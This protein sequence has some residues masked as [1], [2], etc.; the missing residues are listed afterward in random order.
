MES[1]A[2]LRARLMHDAIPLLF[3]QKIGM[4]SEILK[5]VFSDDYKLHSLNFR[6]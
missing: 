2:G 1:P 5:F 3:D 6:L 4:C